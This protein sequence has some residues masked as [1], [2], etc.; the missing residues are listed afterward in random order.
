MISIA[1]EEVARLDR[2]LPVY[3]RQS[4]PD[5]VHYVYGDS[6]RWSAVWEV[7]SR[8]VALARVVRQL[9]R[10]G[11][12]GAWICLTIVLRILWNWIRNTINS[13]RARA[14]AKA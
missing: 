13:R 14:E 2:E 6:G 11:L 4:M 10:M 7:R 5:V 8:G 9:V 1:R 3:G 12:K